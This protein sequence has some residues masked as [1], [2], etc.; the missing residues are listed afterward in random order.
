MEDG[1]IY[2]LMVSGRYV[3]PDMHDMLF[4]TAYLMCRERLKRKKVKTSF[5][6]GVVRTKF[7]SA[8]LG[9]LVGT[10][11]L[12]DVECEEGRLRVSYVVREQDLGDLEE[13]EEMRMTGFGGEF[14]D[15]PVVSVRPNPIK[16][17][18]QTHRA[19]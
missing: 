19:N 8:W 17:V 10:L 14:D 1:K 12:A 6:E 5:C 3:S 7:E 11:F 13:I 16:R 9:P 2:C 18:S 15:P 4:T